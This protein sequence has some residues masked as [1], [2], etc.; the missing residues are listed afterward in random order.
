MSGE[1]NPVM[2]MAAPVVL[3]LVIRWLSSSSNTNSISAIFR[4]GGDPSSIHRAGGSPVGVAVVLLFVLLM[5][6]YQ[7]SG[8]HDDSEE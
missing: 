2:V 5:I 8:V 6:W 3:I 4:G 7:S 1:I